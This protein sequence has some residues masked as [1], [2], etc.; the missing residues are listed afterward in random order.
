MPVA[1]P[2]R[3]PDFANDDSSELER[4]ARAL[5]FM[6]LFESVTYVVLFY[7]WIIQ[8]NDA[9]KAITGF[10]HGLVWMAF[11]AMTVLIREE[12][13]W[14][15]GYTILVIVLGPIG[16]IMVWWRLRTT[17]R[18]VLLGRQSPAADH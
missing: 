11:V 14:T 15:W 17:P 18:E 13:G 4:K 16:G 7:F 1:Y 5:R 2:A 8:P 3:V 12:I 10:V 9:G 6:A